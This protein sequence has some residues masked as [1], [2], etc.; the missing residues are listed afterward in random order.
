[1]TMCCDINRVIITNRGIHPAT[2][3]DFYLPP[4]L[5][6]VPNISRTP[7]VLTV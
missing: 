7:H 1:M 5:T 2:P 3:V 4:T 6:N